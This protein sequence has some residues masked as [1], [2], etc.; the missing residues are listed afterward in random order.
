MKELY[1]SFGSNVGDSISIFRDAVNVLSKVSG[2]YIQKKSSLYET[3]PWGR[4]DQNKF[5]NAVIKVTYEG[6]VE[7]LLLELL[8]IEKLFGRKRIIHWG[9]RTLDLDL[10]YGENVVCQ[11]A[12]LQLPH[13]YFWDRL[14]VLIP[15]A[16]ITPSFS[17]RNQLIMDRINELGNVGVIK[18]E[19]CIW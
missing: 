3:E 13:P 9:P 12:L 15:L 10:L 5:L 14:F 2:L 11:T 1:I 4:V 8:K 7:H 16:E 18:K 19:G 6:N 17:Y